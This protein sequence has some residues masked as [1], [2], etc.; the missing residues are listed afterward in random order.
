M[1]KS[2]GK[3]IKAANGL[4]ITN[5]SKHGLNRAI[6]DLKRV[7]VNPEGIL[8]ALKKPLK[9]NNVLIDKLGRKSQRFIGR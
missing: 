2:L 7:G 8:D 1:G 3:V 5:F 4:K 9:I 6:G